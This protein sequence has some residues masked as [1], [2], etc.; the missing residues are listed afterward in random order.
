M[1]DANG[2]Q[3]CL[4]SVCNRTIRPS[5]SFVPSNPRLTPRGFSRPFNGGLKKGRASG[6]AFYAHNI[7]ISYSNVQPVNS[8]SV[9]AAET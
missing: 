9:D 4:K 5:S 7:S 8:K 3:S 2:G 6:P 1:K